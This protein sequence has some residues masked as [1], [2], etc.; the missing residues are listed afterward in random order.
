MNIVMLAPF[1]IHPKGTVLSRML[2][3]GYALA[4]RGHNINILL[5][6]DEEISITTPVCGGSL[7]LLSVPTGSQRYAIDDLGVSY[8]MM[9]KASSFEPDIMH[10]FKPKGYGGLAGM[11]KWAG[12]R[13]GNE[14]IP[15]V[16]DGDDH[17]GFG[18]M[19][20][21]M[22]YPMAWKLFFH[23]QER[24]LPR[25][26]DRMTL[27]S[28]FLMDHY[29]D[30]GVN[31]E[32]MVH[33]PNGVNPFIHSPEKVDEGLLGLL[34]KRHAGEKEFTVVE[35]E[36]NSRLPEEVLDELVPEETISL[37][38]RFRD[39]GAAR[40]LKIFRSVQEQ[41]SRV[42]FLLVGNGS[43]NEAAGL[44]KGMKKHLKKDSFLFTG[45]VPSSSL[46]G[47]FS[48]SDIAMVPMDDSNITRAKC[49]AKLVD[50]MAMGKA[51]VADGV[52]ENRNYISD[53]ASGLLVRNMVA[54]GSG[55]SFERNRIDTGEFRENV[56]EFSKKIVYLLDDPGEAARLGKAAR[57]RVYGEFNWE[58]LAE[59]AVSQYNE[60]L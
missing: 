8:E 24:F 4:G 11:L 55:S 27:A 34:S 10:V 25:I 28:R 17:E 5:P 49:S 54:Q 43:G 37:F 59:K 14:K 32:H 3:L 12:A 18:G 50:L 33:L 42:K 48:R 56:R 22:D 7:R 51:V 26:S 31:R 21:V 19:N 35:G 36:G 41:N 44:R 13:I 58:K 6:Q 39:H 29:S 30:F 9:Q 20:D 53:K 46:H 16:L 2:P 38:S 47:I 1:G 15:L 23:F 52:G 60:I 45:T 57:E 40:V